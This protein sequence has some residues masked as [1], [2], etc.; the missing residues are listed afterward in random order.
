[1]RLF[2]LNF[3]IMLAMPCPGDGWSARVEDA[4]LHGCIPVHINDNVEPIFG[5]EFEWEKFSVR[6]KQVRLSV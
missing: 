4:I 3:F 1:M 5:T 2:F 6:I